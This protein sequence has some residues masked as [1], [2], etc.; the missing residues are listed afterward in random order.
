MVKPA[1]S[2]TS[3]SFNLLQQKIEEGKEK[4]KEAKLETAKAMGAGDGWHSSAGRTLLNVQFA[5]TAQ[6]LADM[7]HLE[8]DPLIIVPPS[9][10]DI[11]TVGHVVSAEVDYPGEPKESYQYH[12]LGPVDSTI[13]PT[14]K[15]T[16]SEE[17]NKLKPI[18]DRSIEAVISYLSPLGMALL[19]RK[20]GDIVTV[21]GSKTMI[22]NIDVSRFVTMTPPQN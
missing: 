2:I 5:L 17:D 8:S 19:G 14:I 10:N 9:S 21:N 20:I 16:E 11:I 22:N 1:E 15:A 4:V 13:I 6:V 3:L 18:L 7:E 12:L